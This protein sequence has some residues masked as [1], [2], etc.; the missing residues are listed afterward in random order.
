M[1][2]PL[3]YEKTD[4]RA[5]LERRRARGPGGGAAFV[6]CIRPPSVSN[7]ARQRQGRERLPDRHKPRVQPPNRSQ[8][9]PHL[10][11]TGAPGGASARL[12]ASS[13]DSSGLRSRAGGRGLAG[14]VAPKALANS[15]SKAACGLWST[16][17]EVSFEEGLTLTKERVSGE[18][19]RATLA[20]MGVR[21]ERA[22][23]WITS[24]D[25]EYQRK[26]GGATG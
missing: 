3:G 6:R 4:L 8:R 11:R 18:T 26:K 17:A 25:P 2:Y 16:A 14:V 13:Y 15:A 19:I 5:S 23:R 12:Q 1:I 10:Q 20:R 21:W 7:P 24:P 22:K 9:H